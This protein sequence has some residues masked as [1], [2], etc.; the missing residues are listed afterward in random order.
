[1]SQLP[2]P[3]RPSP[4][5][6]WLLAGGSVVEQEATRC[7]RT[8]RWCDRS[9][10]CRREGHTRSHVCSSPACIEENSSNFIQVIAAKKQ[11]EE[12]Y[13]PTVRKS[14]ETRKQRKQRQ[15]KEE[16]KLSYELTM[17]KNKH[18][19]SSTQANKERWRKQCAMNLD[20][21]EEN[22]WKQHKERLEKVAARQ[23]DRAAH[24]EAKGKHI[25]QGNPRCPDCGQKW[26]PGYDWCD[27]CGVGYKHMKKE[28]G[29]E[30]E[31]HARGR[32]GDDLVSASEKHLGRQ[33]AP[34]GASS[35]DNGIT[36][37]PLLRMVNQL[38]SPP[39]SCGKS[40]IAIRQHKEAE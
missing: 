23:S 29:D 6:V 11:E 3:L 12:G 9:Q 1:M 38:S 35:R 18:R 16:E 40:C 32:T 2:R 10:C 20:V 37:A 22:W 5:P 31:G 19:S 15:Q 26:D 4:P 30:K 24:Y 25:G 17:R 33:D 34:A 7:E 39:S 13:G 21:T 27:N 8:C 28:E 36:Y 14:Q